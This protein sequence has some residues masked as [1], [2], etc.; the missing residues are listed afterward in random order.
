MIIIACIAGTYTSL[1]YSSAED[2]EVPPTPIANSTRRGASTTSRN[3]HGGNK[4]GA[5]Q[6][7]G[8]VEVLPGVTSRVTRSS[9]S[10]SR[11]EIIIT[12]DFGMFCVF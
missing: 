7:R 3:G 11:E 12:R 1:D 6:A 5:R 9:R 2:E 4:R 10:N 8:E